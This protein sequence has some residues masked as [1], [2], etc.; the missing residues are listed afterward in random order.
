MKFNYFTMLWWRHALKWYRRNSIKSFGIFL[1]KLREIWLKWQICSGYS[2]NWKFQLLTRSLKAKLKL[3]NAFI[4]L[5]HANDIS[6]GTLLI[7]LVSSSEIMSA[8]LLAFA[9]YCTTLCLRKSLIDSGC[10]CVT[11]NRL[12]RREMTSNLQ[13]RMF[14]WHATNNVHCSSNIYQKVT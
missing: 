6:H 8:Q 13:H 10:F 7:Q 11:Y 9:V 12:V 2:M 3:A 4:W 5:K 14:V 1:M